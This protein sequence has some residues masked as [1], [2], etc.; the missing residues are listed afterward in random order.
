[1]SGHLAQG[2]GPVGALAGSVAAAAAGYL[3]G[4]I[5]FRLR[6]PVAVTPPAGRRPSECRPGI[7]DRPRL[8]M[9]RGLAATTG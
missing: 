4:L 1:V 5:A 7:S 9:P 6:P 2:L 8:G 3:F